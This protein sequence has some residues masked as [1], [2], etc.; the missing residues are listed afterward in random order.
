MR[1][2]VVG[3]AIPSLWDKCAVPYGAAHSLI[4]AVTQHPSSIAHVICT[5]AMR[6]QESNERDSEVRPNGLYFCN[7][8]YRTLF[9]TLLLY[10]LHTVLAPETHFVVALH[11]SP[12]CFDANGMWCRSMPQWNDTRMQC[13]GRD[14]PMESI[15]K[16]IAG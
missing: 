1:G 12:L 8:V 4:Q 11:V 3:G 9:V 10:S 15:V 7:L 5:T 6:M 13:V 14:S 16:N 2:A